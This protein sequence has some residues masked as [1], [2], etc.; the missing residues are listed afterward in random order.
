MAQGCQQIKRRV[1]ADVIEELG[2]KVLV[3]G[4]DEGALASRPRQ[5]LL[6]QCEQFLGGGTQVPTTAGVEQ[7]KGLPVSASTRKKVCACLT[8]AWPAAGRRWSRSRL[9]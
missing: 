1:R 3:V 8:A 5:D 9:E 7:T 6:G 4:D 2:G